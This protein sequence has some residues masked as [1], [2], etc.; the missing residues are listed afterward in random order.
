MDSAAP[1]KPT[2]IW[3][4]AAL[5]AYV[6]G[7]GPRGRTE[8]LSQ[9]V[10]SLAAR[11]TYIIRA[12]LPNWALDE[13]VL[14]LDVLIDH[15]LRNVQNLRVMGMLIQTLAEQRRAAGQPAT[16]ST[17][18]A[19]SAKRMNEAQQAAVA[20]TVEGYRRRHGQP[21]RDL[22]KAWLQEVGAPGFDREERAGG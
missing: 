3:P 8:G 9:V 20:E 22:L 4:G 10:N 17:E 18:F 7:L 5:L 21:E 6:A 12:S 11:Y 15:D 16:L 2:S 14:V 19:Y 13:W 1:K